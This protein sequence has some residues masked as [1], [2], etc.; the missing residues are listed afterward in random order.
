[1]KQSTANKLIFIIELLSL[2][3][4]SVVLICVN[5]QTVFTRPKYP[6]FIGQAIQAYSCFQR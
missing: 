6:K 1:M 4:I 5:I 2:F 3:D